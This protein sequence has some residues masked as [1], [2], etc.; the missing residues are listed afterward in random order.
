MKKTIPNGP[1]MLNLMNEYVYVFLFFGRLVVGAA[2]YS[3]I[4]L[5]YHRHTHTLTHTHYTTTRR[6]YCCYY[7]ML[8][9]QLLSSGSRTAVESI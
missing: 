9:K 5:Y 8:Y 3:S 4:L 7:Y 6:Y 1:K 2:V